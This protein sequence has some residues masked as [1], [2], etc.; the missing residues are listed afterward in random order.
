MAAR[1]VDQPGAMKPSTTACRK[2]TVLL[3]RLDQAGRQT[4]EQNQI[5]GVAVVAG[6]VRHLDAD[7]ARSQI[8]RVA[9]GRYADERDARPYP[10]SLLLGPVES[11]EEAH[12][13]V[14]RGAAGV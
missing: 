3:A 12:Q 6:L 14:A 5:E 9:P 11:I 13:P 4:D 1:R 7:R 2:S 10:V 8:R